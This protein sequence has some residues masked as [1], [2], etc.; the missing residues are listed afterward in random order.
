MSGVTAAGVM[1]AA[2]V[3]GA[4]VGIYSAV[5]SQKAGKE[6]AKL[7]QQAIGDAKTAA[8]KQA[9]DAE[10]AVNAANAKRPNTQTA[11]DSAR[12][13]GKNGGSGTMLTG[14]TGVDPAALQLGKTTLLGG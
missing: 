5:E 9:K 7:Q 3:V 4:G 8:D 10:M 2:S 11:L 1:A 14:P 6:A 13:A 12:L